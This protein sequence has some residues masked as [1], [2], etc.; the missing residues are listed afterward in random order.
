M[1]KNIAIISN[2][3]PTL[4]RTLLRGDS[5]VCYV[6]IRPELT[7]V[8]WYAKEMSEVQQIVYIL[9]DDFLL[10]FYNFSTANALEEVAT[11]TV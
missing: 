11:V 9:I 6:G 4:S 3:R 2:Y 5:F 1:S 10:L 8:I 7:S